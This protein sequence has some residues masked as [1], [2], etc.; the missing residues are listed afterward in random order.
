MKVRLKK[1]VDDSL[2]GG[3][4]VDMLTLNPLSKALTDSYLP[5]FSP[6]PLKALLHKELKTFKQMYLYLKVTCEEHTDVVSS[7][8]LRI[9]LIDDGERLY[10]GDKVN[11][12]GVERCLAEYFR[13]I[14]YGSIECMTDEDITGFVQRLIQD[15]PLTGEYFEIIDK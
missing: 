3:L 1:S 4:E 10:L 13:S 8:A 11:W 6:S 12:N 9:D 14:G 7:M 2:W 5:R 15:I